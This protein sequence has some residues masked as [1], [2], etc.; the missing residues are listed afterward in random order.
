MT[1]LEAANRALVL[2]GVAPVGS[3]ADYSQAARTMAALLPETKKVVL[4]EFPWSFAL[5]IEPLTP[6][7]GSVAGYEHVYAYPADALNVQR[8]YDATRFRGLAEYRV[9]GGVIA[10]HIDGGTV[11]YT[12]FVEDLDIW[13]RQVQECLCTRLA[14][15]AAMSLTGSP[16]MMTAMLEKY[17]AL[18]RTAAQGSIVE[19]NVPL[20]RASDYISVRQ[21]R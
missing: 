6:A 8:V 10:T 12:A 2:I 5:R 16:Q 4:N 19:E 17:M 13:P 18:A 3:L 14:S 15:D 11:E 21:S 1:D 9:A 7:S 20:M